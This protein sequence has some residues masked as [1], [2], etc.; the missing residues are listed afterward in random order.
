[1]WRLVSIILQSPEPAGKHS[2]ILATCLP[3]HKPAQVPPVSIEEPDIHLPGITVWR[4]PNA[5][6]QAIP[7]LAFEQHRVPHDSGLDEASSCYCSVSI[8]EYRRTHTRGTFSVPNTGVHVHTPHQKLSAKRNVQPW[9]FASAQIYPQVLGYKAMS[10]SS[11]KIF[12]D[13][14]TARGL[15]TFFQNRTLKQSWG[16]SA[17]KPYWDPDFISSA[18]AGVHQGAATIKGWQN[19]RETEQGQPFKQS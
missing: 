13:W 5:H 10:P 19:V 7:S 9:L 8:T 4:Q 15:N 2:T 11:G 18:A 12:R 14:T 6:N 16:C 17:T 1:M 3:V